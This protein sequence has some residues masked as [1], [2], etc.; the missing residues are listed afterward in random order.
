MK[1]IRLLGLLF[2]T[3]IGIFSC[4]DSG[5]DPS[6][7]L[8]RIND[9]RLT[10]EAFDRHIAEDVEMDDTYKVTRQAKQ[11]VLEALIRQQILIQEA[12][13]RH[14]DTR[15]AFIEAIQR[16]W[17]ST[18]IRNLLDIKGQEI[19]DR[20]YVS[21]QAIEGRYREM[22]QQRPALPPL[23]QIAEEIEEDLREEKKTRLLE[24]WIEDLKKETDIEINEELLEREGD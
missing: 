21:Q 14:L 2:F 10:L 24:A 23:K 19:N 12:K 6:R 16:Y 22:K 17:E 3:A 1:T 20:I 7:T 4:A 5:E 13:R 9:Y 11:E 15:E 18:L 8:A